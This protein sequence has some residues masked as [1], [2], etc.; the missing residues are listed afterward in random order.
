M[1][2][3]RLYDPATDTSL[4]L[5]LGGVDVDFGALLPSTAQEEGIDAKNTRTRLPTSVVLDVLA[6][7]IPGVGAERAAVEGQIEAWAAAATRLEL[8]VPFVPIVGDLIIAGRGLT[9][10]DTTT[11]RWSVALEEVREVAPSVGDL[12]FP[13]AGTT[14]GGNLADELATNQEGGEQ[15]GTPVERSL[16]LRLLQGLGAVE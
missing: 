4:L 6:T 2:A 11:G 13:R 1:T 5:D 14:A 9:I 12:A 16:S 7:D 10:G 3:P 15:S 8:I